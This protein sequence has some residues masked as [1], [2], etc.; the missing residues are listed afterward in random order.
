[1]TTNLHP[2]FRP[3]IHAVSL[4]VPI[5]V[6]E[7]SRNF[8]VALL[9]AIIA[10]FTASELVRL[11]GRKVPLITPFTLRMS[12]PGEQVHFI[13]RPVYLAIGIV[14]AL[15]IFPKNIAF[16]SI[17]I[18]GVGDPAASYVGR[19]IGQLHVGRKTL[20]G[21]MGGLVASS[22]VASLIV[23]PVA[24]FVGSVAAM[25]LELLGIFDDNLTMP[26][27]AG[28]IMLLLTNL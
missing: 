18:V 26:I 1:V 8:A 19:K 5:V 16:A 4:A 20:E 28:A 17:A 3:I 6:E 22:L 27:G 12:Q 7:T 9:L 24:A 13:I 2:N 21:F 14:V 23:S 25:C 10:I 11:K 15:L